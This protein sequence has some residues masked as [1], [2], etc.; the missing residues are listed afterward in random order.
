MKIYNDTKPQKLLNPQFGE[1]Q[2]PLFC[3][4]EDQ[5]RFDLGSFK[6]FNKMSEL[7]ITLDNGKKLRP[8]QV[9][10]LFYVAEKGN[11]RAC[12][13]DET[14][15]G[16]TITVCGL[17]HAFRHILLPAIVVCKATLKIQWFWEL[18]EALKSLN[19][20]IGI[21]KNKDYFI[22]DDLDILI[23]SYDNF[24]KMDLTEYGFKTII[25]DE[26]QQIK[27]WDAQ[28]TVSIVDA[29]KQVPYVI[30]TTATPAK[31]NA[32]ELY[33]MFHALDPKTFNNRKEFSRMCVQLGPNKFGGIDPWYQKKFEEMIDGK[34]IR[35]ERHIVAPELPSALYTYL[36]VQISQGEIL[37]EL[38]REM[39]NFLAI[40]EEIEDNKSILASSDENERLEYDGASVANKAMTLRASMMKMRHII[41]RAKVPY[42]LDY[43]ET[44][45]NDNPEKKLTVFIHHK[46]VGD[47]LLEGI[48]QLINEGRL[49]INMPKLIRGG[50]NE[51]ERNEIVRQCTINNGWLSNDP[52][53]RLIIG[54]TLAA[55]E[56]IN[57]QQC[58]DALLAERQ[59]N[60]ANEDQA[61][62]GRFSRI[63]AI[64][65]EHIFITI[66]SMLNSLDDWFDSTVQVKRE[67]LKRTYGDKS[68]IEINKMIGDFEQDDDF[69]N[70]IAV[71]G[72]EWL[73]K[74]KVNT[75][76]Q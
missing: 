56:G 26:A 24:K 69:M 51:D 18:K 32:F 49:D 19:L 48:Q 12:V 73:R 6:Y 7:Q 54:S 43:I 53:D 59:F 13:G 11:F 17:F 63:G 76:V 21:A 14:G 61:A 55:G 52:K 46:K 2:L 9:E 68:E 4:T 40:K 39:E 5:I 58:C 72:R 45:L 70:I 35:H 1:N 75:K 74:A 47:R 28:R 10:N 41:G 23:V 71:K 16:K 44:F 50:M 34:F 20:N 38:K 30:P 29:C 65:T 15:L 36:P 62:P 8:Y 37:D 25:L 57:L 66:M 33:P 42:I 67:E 22:E 3:G 27:N 64:E 31:N 60:P